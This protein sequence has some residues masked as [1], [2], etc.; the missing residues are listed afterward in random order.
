MAEVMQGRTSDGARARELT[1]ND[2]PAW[3]GYRPDVLGSLMA[4]HGQDAWTMAIYFTS[5]VEARVGEQQEPPESIRAAMAELDSL[6]VGDTTF[7]DLRD[8]WL[9]SP[10]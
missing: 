10:S 9:A 1:S 6:S 7:I 4:V 2:D 3:R 8:P 5:E